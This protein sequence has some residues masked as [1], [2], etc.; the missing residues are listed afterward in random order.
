M[1][2]HTD[3]AHPDEASLLDRHPMRDDEGQIRPEFV[4]EVARAIQADDAIFLRGIVG[5]LHEADLGDLIAALKAEE[6]V[7]LVELTGSDFD[8]SA[9]N[10]VDETV[11]EEILEELEPE[12]VAEGVRELESDDAVELLESLDE[13]DREEVLEKL[14]PSERDVIERSLEYP[15]NS[16]GRRMQ[17]EFIAVPPDWTV[18]QAIDYMRETSDLPDRFYEIYAADADKRWQGAVALDALLR[19]RRMV[20]LKELIDEERRR[21]SVLDDQAEVARMFGKYNLVAAP[22]LDTE[23]R[24]VGVITIDDVVDVIEEEADEDLKALGGVSSQE[25]LSDTVWTIARGRFNWLLV[26]LATAFLASSVLGLFEGQLEKMVALAVLAPIVASQG[27]NAAT[28]TMTVA[29]RALATRELGANNAWRVVIREAMVGLVNGLAFAVITGVA[30]VAWFKI[31][32]LGVVI[33]LAIICNLVAGALGGILIPMLLER[34][35]ADPAVASGTFVTTVTD[36]V[37]FFSFLGIA[38]LW[39]GLK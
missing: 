26:N 39:F 10:E 30:A 22:V 12:E 4:E 8:F 1:A 32:G 13:E 38:T 3:V 21:V 33:G 7:K 19:S 6:R 37:G 18:G 9:L 16:A 5:E 2:D 29:V 15:E 11:R 34:V 35:K 20:P 31:P 23:N 17:T 25:E 27:G 14:P 28:Q 36:V 24:L